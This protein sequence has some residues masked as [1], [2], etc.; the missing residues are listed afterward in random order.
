MVPGV[1]VKLEKLPLTA[2][3]KLDRKALP[4]AESGVPESRREPVAPRNA[5]EEIVAGI[6]EQVLGVGQVSVV[7][8]FFELGGHSLLATR[9][10]SRIRNVLGVDLPLRTLFR[11]PTVYG[12]AVE[13]E[14]L[15][16]RN[17][18]ASPP[19]RRGERKG[20]FPLSF[21]QQRLWF[22]DQLEP[23]TS[24]YNIGHA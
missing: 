18:I 10:V 3:G 13:I 15:R 11:S 23:G 17:A 1:L 6:W 12:L 9:V 7:D 8:N 5:V 20:V 21:A 19:L 4:E 24:I 22:I 2:N 14:G 16:L